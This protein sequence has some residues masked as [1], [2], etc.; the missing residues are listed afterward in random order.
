MRA[1]FFPIVIALSNDCNLGFNGAFCT[2]WCC[3]VVPFEVKMSR[4]SALF[5]QDWP[6]SSR[7]S[8]CCHV[9]I[10]DEGLSRS[11]LNGLSDNANWCSMRCLSR[12]GAIQW[13]TL[14]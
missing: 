6:E 3:A 10:S 11:P 12:C 1:I 5:R 7:R 8:P 9:S 14:R 2:L 13:S 4:T